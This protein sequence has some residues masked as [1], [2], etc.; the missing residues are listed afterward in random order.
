MKDYEYDDSLEQGEF[1]GYYKF[2]LTKR[3]DG[4]SDGTINVISPSSVPLFVTP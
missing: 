2:N 1:D 3:L 4:I